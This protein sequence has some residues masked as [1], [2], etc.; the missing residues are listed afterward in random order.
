MKNLP[1]VTQM[2]AADCQ[3]RKQHIPTRSLRCRQKNV[4]H[5][6]TRSA[7]GMYSKERTVVK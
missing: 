7:D 6:R 4:T 1:D 3:V 5:T 2:S